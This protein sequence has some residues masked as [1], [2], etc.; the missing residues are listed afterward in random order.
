MGARLVRRNIALAS[1]LVDGSFDRSY[2]LMYNRSN[3]SDER[4]GLFLCTLS[5]TGCLL[6]ALKLAFLPRFALH[7]ALSFPSLFLG[8]QQTNSANLCV[9]SV[10]FCVPSLFLNSRR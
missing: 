1:Y 7:Q 10:A 3:L 9:S 8:P 6:A 4:S 5:W 2:S